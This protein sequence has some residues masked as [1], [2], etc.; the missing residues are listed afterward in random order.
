MGITYRQAGVDIRKADDALERLKPL[1]RK[2]HGPEV[3][4]DRG[5]FAALYA[6]SS[7]RMRDP[8][9]VSSTD[10]VGTK[11]RLAET[12]AD[13]E[14][15]GVDAVG[16]NVN[17]VLVYGARPLF[18]L[19]YIAMGRLDRGV[20]A[21]L[22]RGIAKG[23][24]ES[25]CALIGG[26]T[27]EMPG[28]YQGSDYD[29][30]GF[31]VAVVERSK[32]LDGSAV[33]AGDALVGLASSGVHANGFSLVRKA[34]GLA[35]LKRYKRQLLVPTR[36][37]VKPILSLLRRVPVSALAHVTGGG[38]T[39]RAASLV[40]RKPGLTARWSPGNWPVP[41]IFQRIQR[42]GGI[43]DDDMYKTFNMGIGMIVA[44]RPSS[45]ATVI[46]SMARAG[47]RAW[48]IGGIERSR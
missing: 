46:R 14:A 21:A 44:C 36:L 42:A 35:E 38:I 18:F 15:I 2:T 34:L 27:A 19:D 17:D 33:R 47:I 4:A 16:M 25:G 37:Y 13:H 11:P 28:V 31:C 12:A 24:A 30:A 5:Q 45:A 43:A 40:A 22:L 32:I 41:Q 39:R 20:Y 29:V 1:I 7:L 26:E 6:L 8:V 10:G 48:T 9:L 23:C 3:L